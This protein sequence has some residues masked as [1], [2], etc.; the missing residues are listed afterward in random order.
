MDTTSLFKQR[1]TRP[2]TYQE[3]HNELMEAYDATL[4][5]DTGENHIGLSEFEN[6]V[7]GSLYEIWYATYLREQ[8]GEHFRLSFD[9]F[10]DR[11]RWQIM[12]ML[13]AVRRRM[14]ILN[15]DIQ[16]QLE[17]NKEMRELEKENKGRS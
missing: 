6:P 12:I 14:A 17:E 4:G 15:K 5:L 2:I 8:I 16:A 3:A 13:E 10:L 7:T 1:S 11:P 9:E